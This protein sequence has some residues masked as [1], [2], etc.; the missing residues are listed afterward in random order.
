MY[1][2]NLAL[3][4]KVI[5]NAQSI[6][7]P[8]PEIH[9]AQTLGT[10]LA[11][12]SILG[13]EGKKVDVL[14]SYVNLQD[15]IQFL[16]LSNITSF[17]QSSVESVISIDT[18]HYPV[19]SIKYDRNENEL[20]IY[21]NS[22][23]DKFYPELV[24]S[25]PGKYPYDLIITLDTINWTQLGSYFMNSPHIFLETPSLAI[26]SRHI[27]YPYSENTIVDTNYKSSAEMIFEYIR[28]YYNNCLQDK[29]INNALLLS[30]ILTGDKSFITEKITLQLR[31]LPNDYSLI[32]QSLD[33]IISDNHRLLIGRIL[34]HLDFIDCNHNGLS[35][36]YAYS[37]LFTHDFTKTNTTTKDI[38]LIYSNLFQYLPKDIIGLHIVG[39]NGKSIKFGYLDFPNLDMM[40][41]QTNLEGEYQEGVL[42]Y[43]YPS[44]K[45]IHAATQ[46]LNQKILDIL[47]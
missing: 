12:S 5:Q 42:V 10:A 4:H 33:S 11:L 31:E 36:R 38:I 23:S 9:G 46:E 44:E 40:N 21:L 13:A 39:D 28:S 16:D 22:P 8:I 41:F 37:K 6:L 45:D 19:D 15:K 24:S 20:R 1:S 3:I 35:T 18:T 14:S 17:I 43:N 32:N 47:Q 25:Y 29:D 30:L 27:H 34:A 26:S 2:D 7:I